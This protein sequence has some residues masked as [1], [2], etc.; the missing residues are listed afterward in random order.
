MARGIPSGTMGGYPSIEDMYAA[1]RDEIA[2]AIR[3]SGKTYE[4]IGED[5]G[6]SRERVRQIAKRYGLCRRAKVAVD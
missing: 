6:I 4:Q 1:R 3:S 2:E 5:F